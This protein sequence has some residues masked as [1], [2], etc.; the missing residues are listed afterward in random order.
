MHA[1]S[2]SHRSIASW[3]VV[4]FVSTAMVVL[5]IPTG[6]AAQAARRTPS[7]APLV[8][9]S[10]LTAPGEV[11][12]RMPG[13]R[14]ERLRLGPDVRARLA[15]PSDDVYRV[16]VDGT[17][18]PRALRYVVRAGGRPVGFGIPRGDERAVV[19]ITTDDAVL[20][21]ALT[22]RYEGR[23][24]PA[25]D[26]D[27]RPGVE[28]AVLP[29]PGPFDVTVTDYDFG[30]RAYQ[31]AGL[32]GRVELRAAVYHPTDLSSGPY[33]IVLFLHGNHSA[34]Y[35][36]DRSGYTWPCRDGWRPIPNHEGYG[37]LGS[38]LASYGYI[39]ASVSGNGVNVLGNAVADTGMRQ[40][41]LLLERHLELWEDW[42]TIGSDPFETSFVGAVDMDRIG[43]MGHSRGGEG[44]V[45]QAI[46]DRDRPDPFGIDAILPLAPVDFNRATINDVA[47]GVILPACD[48]DV[49]DLQGVHFVDDSRYVVPGDPTSKAAMTAFGANHN[50]FNTVWSPS[51]GIPGSFDDGYGCSDRLSEPQQRR[52]GATY[53]AAFLRHHVGGEVDPLD[54]WSGGTPP[55]RL[56]PARTAVSYLAPD[57][58]AWR[59]DVDRFDT[60]TGLRRTEPGGAVTVSGAGLWSW[61]ANTD[62]STCIPGDLSWYDIHA[63]RSYG[64]PLPPGLQQGV[65]GWDT[66]TFG[67]ASIRFAIGSADVS[68]LD[69]LSFRTV[70]NVGYYWT[71]YYDVTDMS[72]V[73]EDGS[74]NRTSVAAADVG[75]DA[76]TYPLR[77]RRGQTE[78]KV[79]LH[80]LRF[81]L[82]AFAGVD[83]TDVVAVEFTFDRIPL[84]VIDVAD[85]AFQRN[86]G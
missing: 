42:N 22:A 36:G 33:P 48:G 51:S 84:G 12:R 31:P 50:F 76:L 70:P 16:T 75:N 17:F 19:A 34:C 39:V 23:R 25:P 26:A 85:L 57:L 74:G 15:D 63:S 65:I 72:V 37:Y 9:R 64:E 81:P 38:R 68:G 62:Y 83:L 10:G 43:V 27:A 66:A 13:V 67:E 53:M 29:T 49:Y 47:L 77:Y 79:I 28:R 80:Q 56:D 6:G 59:L 11:V 32:G 41:G 2:R 71:R 21:D 82:E 58:P 54:L 73:L 46:V 3:L 14:V 7:L 44:A 40:R 8:V 55:A 4:V 69:V 52:V 86:G 20:T 24:R 60:P 78:G 5:A 18:P 1:T 61:C 45:Y 30:D 35:R